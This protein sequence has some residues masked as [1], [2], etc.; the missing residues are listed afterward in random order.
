MQWI[1]SN[2]RCHFVV[3]LNI[4]TKKDTRGRKR[5]RKEYECQ[6]YEYNDPLF[7]LSGH[8]YEDD[9]SLKGEEVHPWIVT[10]THLQRVSYEKTLDPF[11]HKIHIFNR[12]RLPCMVSGLLVCRQEVQNQN[13][14]RVGQS[15]MSI[16]TAAH[17]AVSL[18]LSDQERGSVCR[19]LSKLCKGNALIWIA[20]CWRLFKQN[21]A[22]S[23]T[24]YLFMNEWMEWRDNQYGKYVV[25]DK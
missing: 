17:I 22:D 19:P 20:N 2:L 1:F 23:V 16:K 6:R 14:Q 21:L 13:Q 12:G 25:L 10:P 3:C 24:L 5:I 4:L 18:N 15:T 9:A 8:M 11:F 7:V